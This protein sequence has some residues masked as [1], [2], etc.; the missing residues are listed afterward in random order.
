MLFGLPLEVVTMLGSS[1]FSG[2]MTM[3]SQSVKA[4]N[5][6]FNNMIKFN[7]QQHKNQVEQ[8]QADPGFSWTRRI[9]AVVIVVGGLGLLYLPTLAGVPQIIEL[10][11]E[12][13]GLFGL[14]SNTTTEFHETNA[15]VTPEWLKLSIFSIMGLY[16]GNSMTRK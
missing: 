8:L 5:E 14:I 7:M 9:I 6:Q 3:W 13:T 15:I 12:S 2:V 10:T 11:N 1:L 4:K 16:F